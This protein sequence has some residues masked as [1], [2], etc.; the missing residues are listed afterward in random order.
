MFRSLHMKL[1]LILLLLITSLMTIVGAFMMTSITSFYIDEFY[2]QIEKVFGD[3]NPSNGAF[4]N[5]LRREAA[6]EDFYA[7]VERGELSGAAL[8]AYLGKLFQAHL[9]NPVDCVVLGCTHYPFVRDTIQKML[10]DKV[11]IF[12]G[13]G[14]T[15][16]ETHRRLAECGLLSPFRARGRVTIENSSESPEITDLCSMLLKI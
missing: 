16:R 15:A 14:G 6:Q 2:Q 8:E 13:G 10:G 5:S 12:D 1:V 3:S 7:A 4:V 9:R 11:A